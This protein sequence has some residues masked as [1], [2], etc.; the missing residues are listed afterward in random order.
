MCHTV[1]YIARVARTGTGILALLRV[2]WL[3]SL[4]L[5]CVLLQICVLSFLPSC[6]KL[7]NADGPQ[8][9]VQIHCAVLRTAPMHASR[10]E[11]VDIFPSGPHRKNM[12]AS[13]A[14][15]S[16]YKQKDGLGNATGRDLG[17]FSMISLLGGH[18]RSDGLSVQVLRGSGFVGS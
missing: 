12:C 17:V 10:R 15:P 3:P 16:L 8:E 14:V 5:L 9:V 6:T 18:S 4:L 1:L 2:S 11:A 13:M 7:L